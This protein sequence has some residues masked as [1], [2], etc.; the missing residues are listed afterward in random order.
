MRARHLVSSL[1]VALAAALNGQRSG[2]HLQRQQY[3]DLHHSGDRNLRRQR[4]GR[5]QGGGGATR[6]NGGLGAFVSGDISLTQGT[7]LEI[8][9]GGQG[10]NGTDFYAGGGGGGSFVY[11]AGAPQPLAVAGGGGGGGGGSPIDSGGGP[12]QNG[13]S[14]Q[15]G[16]DVSNS[17][18]GG[19]GGSDGSGGG[20]GPTRSAGTAVAAGAGV[21]AGAKVAIICLLRP[22]AAATAHQLSWGAALSRRAWAPAGASA[23]AAR[24]GA[25]A[26]GAATPAAGA[27]PGTRRRRRRR[28]IVPRFVAHQPA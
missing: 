13:T 4:V 21:A 19:Y 26:A 3:P 28:R 23:A 8:V 11:V 2:I 24:A 7:A 9:V 15:A 12:G 17:G 18:Y 27:G 22:A 5:A 16:F 25:G 10:V 20:G 1:L 14:G 6:P